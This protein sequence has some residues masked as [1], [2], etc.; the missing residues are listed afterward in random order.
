MKRIVLLVALVS[1]L[2]VGA[3][4]IGTA[5]AKAFTPRTAAWLT[6][7]ECSI[8]GVDVI[9]DDNWENDVFEDGEDDCDSEDTFFTVCIDNVTLS[10]LTDDGIEPMLADIRENGDTAAIGACAPTSKWT[11][12][13]AREA[14]CSVAGNTWPDGRPIAAGTFLD[15]L[16]GQP[17]TD[18]HYTGAVVAW[19]VQGV[20]LTC[21][22]TPAQAA[23]AATSILRAGGA[24]DLEVP[25]PGV[26]DYAI[27]PYVP[28]K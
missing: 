4:F 15:L 28:A 27:Y 14:Y 12:E 19:W 16:A 22:L 20:G 1:G 8:D 7:G 5:S 25:I 21:S 11:P 23:L 2:A 13:P 24:G 10:I 9:D 3:A 18:K 17:T 6:P 26:P